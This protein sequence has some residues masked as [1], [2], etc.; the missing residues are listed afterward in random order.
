MPPDRE[1][2]DALSEADTADQTAYGRH[3]CETILSRYP[4]HCPTLVVHARFL[5]EL[6]QYEEAAKAL[7]HAETVVPDERRHLVLAQRGHLLEFMGDYSGAEELHLEAHE[8]DPDDAAYLIYAGSAAFRRGDTFRAEELVR[9]ALRCSDGCLEEAHFNLGGYLLAQKR[10]EEA[11]D[12]Y[13]RALEIDPDYSI[14]KKRLADV[15]RVITSRGEQAGADQP[16][17]AMNL[18]SE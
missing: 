6:S 4:D 13:L 9:S 5:I 2:L 7:D 11:R 1:L 14:A 17:A 12:C 3:I 15:E 16:T 18:K 10:Y 8:L